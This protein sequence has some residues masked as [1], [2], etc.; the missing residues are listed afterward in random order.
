MKRGVFIAGTDTEV[1]KTR[2]ATRLLAELRGR[3]LEAAGM[4]PVECGG[5]GD[6]LAIH[7]AS[8][9]VDPLDRINPVPL[10]E[11]V[12]PAA[13]AQPAGIDFRRVEACFDEL[14]RGRDLVLVE[15]AGGWLV[16]LDRERT[17]ADL[18]AFLGLPVVLVAPNRLGVL[19]HA[20][21]TSRAIASSG[22]ECRAVF[23]NT[24]PGNDGDPSRGSNAR[25]LREHL[26]GIPVI[27]DDLPALADLLP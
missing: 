16:P 23:L 4:K 22:L 10:A 5:R 6:A 7:E 2:V 21:L 19:N 3:G 14:A 26:P 11:P 1:G 13:A 20:L 25:I 27:E 24:L 12:A 18:A 9:R 8:G 17:M 15:G